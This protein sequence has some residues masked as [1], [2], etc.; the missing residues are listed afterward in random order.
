[1]SSDNVGIEQARKTLGDL[2]TQVQQTGTA[3]TLTRNGK[4]AVRIAPLEAAMTETAY[5]IS[6]VTG[7]IVPGAE[8]ADPDGDIPEGLL[9][10][11]DPDELAKYL[12]KEE[13]P[14]AADDVNEEERA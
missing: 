2:V 14:E 9:S 6:A 11:F 13:L 4:P 5:L 1:M 12:T 10:V 3:I 8:L 7:D